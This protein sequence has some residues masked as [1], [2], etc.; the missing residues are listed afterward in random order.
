[1]LADQS[2]GLHPALK[3]VFPYDSLHKHQELALRSI[4]SG[5][6]TIIATGTGSGKTE[7]FLLPILDHCL[8]LRD[9]PSPSRR[10]SKMPNAVV[11]NGGEVAGVGPGVTAVLVYPMNALVNDQLDRLRRLLAGTRITFARYTGETPDRAG[12]DLVQLAASRQYAKQKLQD[13]ADGI[14]PLPIPWEECYDRE[15]I[16]ARKPRLLLTVLEAAGLIEPR[17]S[18]L[19]RCA[20]SA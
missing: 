11:G 12:D 13:D 19:P 6:H 20:R 2:L 7:G 15:S 14:A 18:S 1:M 5:Q 3:G 4:K 17:R 8:H 16:L 10:G 9:L